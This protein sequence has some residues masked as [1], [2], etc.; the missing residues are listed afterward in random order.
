MKDIKIVKEWDEF[1]PVVYDGPHPG[2]QAYSTR[3]LE[4]K[5]RDM[6]RELK[7]IKCEYQ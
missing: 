7:M 4:K 3:V 1:P 2:A 6:E 5:Y